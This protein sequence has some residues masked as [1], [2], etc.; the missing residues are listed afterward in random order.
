MSSPR[1]LSVFNFIIVA[2]NLLWIALVENGYIYSYSFSDTIAQYPTYITPAK[3][4]YKI[5]TFI[6]FVM[7]LASYSMFYGTQ[8][9]HPNK[10]TILKVV[11]IDFWLILNQLA[12]GISMSLKHNDNFRWSLLFTGIALISIMVV[13]NKIQI[14]RLTSNSFTRYFIR[15]AFG[16]Y[17]GWLMYVFA[18]NLA[19]IFEKWGFGIPPAGQF[20]VDVILLLIVSVAMLSYSYLKCLPMVSVVLTWAAYGAYYQGQLRPRAE[21]EQVGYLLI[22]LIVISVVVAILT[23]MRCNKNRVS[24]P[25]ELIED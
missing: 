24:K 22:A 6:A 15:L 9:A 13:N 20:Y 1:T 7:V 17:T 3:F 23:Y 14:Q 18:F 12:V 8:K 21:S 25:M 2:L 11:K 4:A 5:W 16:L 19:V 10:N